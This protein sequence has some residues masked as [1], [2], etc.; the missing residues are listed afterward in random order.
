MIVGIDIGNTTVEIGF[1]Y[2]KEKIKSYKLKTDINKTADDWFLDFYQITK[3]EGKEI[4]D[5]VVSSVVPQVETKISKA[6]KRLSNKNPLIIGKDIYIPIKNNYK[7]PEEVGID[8]LVNAYA[9][10]EEYGYPSVV[11][12]FGTAITFDVISVEGE[13]EGGAIF[14][15]IEAS[16]NALFSKT[17][18]LP[19]VDLSQ[20]K[21]VVGKTT[22][23]SIKSGIYYGYLSL[24]EGMI[25][26]INRETGYK[27]KV[28]ITGGN[29]KLISEGIKV[30]SIHDRYLTMKGIL[31]IYMQSI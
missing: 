24:V 22:S 16:I 10:I 6:V 9:T 27:N 21:G 18:K 30:P 7:N 25:D 13:Y 4:K 11:I 15:G 28:V 29:G 31:F 19:A 14:P 5:F 20:I 8:R 2:S 1:I 23:Q 26:R 12:D 3:L 17:A